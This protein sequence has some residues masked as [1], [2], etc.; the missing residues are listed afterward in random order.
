ML[1]LR[2][3]VTC[4]KY[5]TLILNIFYFGILMVSIIIIMGKCFKKKAV[6]FYIIRYS[7]WNIKEKQMYTGKLLRR[8]N[9]FTHTAKRYLRFNVS[10]FEVEIMYIEK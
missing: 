10:I 4:I 9:S 8:L 1:Y 6:T 2:Y 7:V 5:I 3:V